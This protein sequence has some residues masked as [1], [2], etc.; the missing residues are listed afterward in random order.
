M[1]R[2]KYTKKFDEIKDHQFWEQLLKIEK[3]DKE[4]KDA[5]GIKKVKSLSRETQIHEAIAFKYEIEVY[6]TGDVHIIQIHTV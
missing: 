5:L 3:D 4:I 1:F 2:L 6:N